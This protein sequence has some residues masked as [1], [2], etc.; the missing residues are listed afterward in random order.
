MSPTAESPAP[1]PA[2][3]PV[4][5][6]VDDLDHAVRLC[7][8]VLGSAPP[9]AAWD[10]K[11]GTLEWDCW[12]TVEHLADDLFAYAVQ[13]GL[14]TP[15]LD[16]DL[17]FVHDSRRPGGPGNTVY[18]DRAAGPAGLLE[19]LESCGALLIAMV[20]TAPPGVRAH[21]VFGIADAEGFAAMGIVETLVH[22]HDVAQGLG[23]RW[24]PPGGLC[25]GVLTR[26]FPDVRGGGDPWR[27]LLWATGRGELPG[28]PRRTAWRWYG[29]PR[30]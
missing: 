17:S 11:A 29:E 18:A 23:L 3:A 4:P 1:V 14:R 15:P 13:L 24:S 27:T 19:V 9:A 22:T 6:T 8:D 20:R 21:H 2:P 10:A 28:R 16:H 26:L 7:L 30:S 12:E 5:V 25:A